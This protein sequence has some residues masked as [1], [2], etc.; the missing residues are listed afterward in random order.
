MLIILQSTATH[1][2]WFDSLNTKFNSVTN[3]NPLTKDMM[4]GHDSRVLFHKV[5]LCLIIIITSNH[6][7][8]VKS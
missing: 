8:L 5:T 1:V 7:E 4:S 6:L 3:N 2:L